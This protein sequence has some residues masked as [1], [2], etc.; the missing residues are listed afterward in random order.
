MMI[1]WYLDNIVMN[2]CCIYLDDDDV[3]V[4]MQ[5]ICDNKLRYKKVV[6]IN[7]ERNLLCRCNLIVS[8]QG[9]SEVS[10]NQIAL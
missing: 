9:F 7:C 8:Y 10:M 2:G 6:I 4:T 3:K 1:N 5:P